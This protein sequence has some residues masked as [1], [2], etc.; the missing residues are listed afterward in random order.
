MAVKEICQAYALG[1]THGKREVLKELDLA[2][3]DAQRGCAKEVEHIWAKARLEAKKILETLPL[4]GCED[5]S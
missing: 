5:L 2:L 4:P 1:R 3:V